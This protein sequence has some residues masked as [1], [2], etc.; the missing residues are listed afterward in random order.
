[1][2]HV[3][4]LIWGQ[5]QLE[6]FGNE[7]DLVVASDVIYVRTRVRV[8][9]WCGAVQRIGFQSNSDVRKHRSELWG[10]H[11]HQCVQSHDTQC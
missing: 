6:D 8:C 11:T 9:M 2:V 10:V 5:S 7:W 1:M 3:R 4:E